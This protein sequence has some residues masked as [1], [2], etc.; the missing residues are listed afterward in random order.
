MAVIFSFTY[1]ASLGNFAAQVEGQ[2]E[3]TVHTYIVARSTRSWTSTTLKSVSQ[4][5]TSVNYGARLPTFRL[6]CLQGKQATEFFLGAERCVGEELRGP[7]GPGAS[8]GRCL[9]LSMEVISSVTSS[10]CFHVQM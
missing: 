5:K 7:R 1:G 2:I 4:H 9:S 6:A 8:T 3:G 10:H